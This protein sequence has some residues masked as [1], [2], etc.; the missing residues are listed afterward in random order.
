MIHLCVEAA[1]AQT[2]LGALCLKF[3]A[4]TFLSAPQESLL[5]LYGMFGLIKLFPITYFAHSF[6]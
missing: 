6:I 1:L 5:S 3:S 4:E 2:H